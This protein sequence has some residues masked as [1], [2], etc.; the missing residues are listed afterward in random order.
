MVHTDFGIDEHT[1]M[2]LIADAYDLLSLARLT[3]V[4]RALSGLAC[5][6]V[7]PSRVIKLLG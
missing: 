7:G 2:Q 3:A 4:G 5:L 1:G 6:R